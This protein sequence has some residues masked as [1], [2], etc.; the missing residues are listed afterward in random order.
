LKNIDKENLMNSNLQEARQQSLNLLDKTRRETRSI[1]SRLD[2]G[3]VVNTDERAWR[4]RDVV[5]HLGVW[6]GEAARSLRAYARGGEYFCITANTKYD[7]YNGPAADERS[8]WTLELVWAE[9][10]ASHDQ[11]KSIIETMPLEKWD[12]EMLFPW[13]ERGTVEEFIK[14]MMKHETNDHCNPI[15]QGTKK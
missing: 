12:G 11:L 4:V 14:R 1:L 8:A 2:P 7:E 9:Y 3:L 15:V 6:N 10:E 13:N 5:G